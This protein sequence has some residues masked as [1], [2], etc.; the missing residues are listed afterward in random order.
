MMELINASIGG[1]HGAQVEFKRGN[2][3]TGEFKDAYEYIGK[4][5]KLTVAVRIRLPICA[6]LSIIFE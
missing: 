1:P 3:S 6:R 5:Y 2:H 4:L